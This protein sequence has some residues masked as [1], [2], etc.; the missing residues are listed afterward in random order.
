MCFKYKRIIVILLNVQNLKFYFLIQ[1]L[2]LL[3][4][5]QLL[6]YLLTF[7]INFDR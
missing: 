4:V 6:V 3:I 7:Y 5:K 2:I 1:V